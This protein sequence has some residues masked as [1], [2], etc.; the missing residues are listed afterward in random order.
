VLGTSYIALDAVIIVGLSVALSL[1]VLW[2]I[3]W[4]IPHERL[5]PHNEVSGFVYAVIG[6][7]YA[8]ILG[9]A[10]ITVWEH[11][12]DSQS[13][14]HSEANAVANIYRIASGLPEPSR[15]EIQTAALTYASTVVEE[16]W[17]AMN[18]G[19]APVQQAIDDVDTLWS[20][21][22]AVALTTSTE[23]ALYAQGLEQLSELSSLRRERLE[24]NDAA[25]LGIMWG[26]VVG[27]AILTVLFPCL[28]GVESRLVHSL[29]IGTLAASIGL[30]LLLTY[31]L[32]YPFQGDVAIEPEGFRRVLDQFS[33]GDRSTVVRFVG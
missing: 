16:E 6:V 5:T 26:V 29:I 23:E 18:D 15:G 31:D 21:F 7:I 20:S 19:T 30:L 33:S 13:N 28:L 3:R 25:L 1:L 10:V 8:I 22:D 17:P 24:D 2:V 4:A 32:N 11:Y 9:F 12:N 14:A 27:G